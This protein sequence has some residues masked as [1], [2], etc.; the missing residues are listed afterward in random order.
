MDRPTRRRQG[1]WRL[2]VDAS[3][4]IRVT[5]LLADPRGYLTNLT[6][7]NRYMVGPTPPSTTGGRIRLF[8][9]AS[10]RTQQGFLRIINW[11]DTDG[12]VG[13]RGLRDDGTETAEATLSIPAHG[14][15]HVN[16]GDLEFGNPA[17]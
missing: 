9:S 10:H 11:S 2:Q 7:D 5:T 4:A 15:R 17:N 6:V 3:A 1:T 14:A 12:T 16:S 8:K 13:I